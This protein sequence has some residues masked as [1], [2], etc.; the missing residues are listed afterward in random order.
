MGVLNLLN[1]KIIISRSVSP[2]LNLALEDFLFKNST[3][4]QCLLFYSNLPSVI[5]GRNQNPWTELNVR[6]CRKDW[7]NIVRRQSGGGTVFH[8]LGNVNY[9]VIMDRQNFSHTR[10]AQIMAKALQRS[11]IDASVNNRHDIVL[12]STGEKLSGSA[13]KIARSRCYHHG[14]MLLNT[15]LLNISKYLRSYTTGI[16]SSGVKSVRSPVV[17]V[18][19]PV[20]KFV[21]DAIH[22][23][24]ETYH[25]EKVPQITSITAEDIMGIEDIAKME[26]QLRSWNWTFGQTPKFQQTL[27]EEKLF[28][29]PL[30][31]NISVLHGRIDNAQ[32]VTEDKK[33]SDELST[34]DWN[35]LRYDSGSVNQILLQHTPSEDVRA[36]V[37]WLA[38]TI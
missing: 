26:E 22:T 4:K 25:L 6:Q 32:F 34:Y 10:N 2:Y 15:D 17:N 19:V 3:A 35:G 28:Q 1:A 13:Y 21:Y 33:L 8:D 14:T 16:R 27:K 5:I 18:N 12:S 24:L 31:V 7:V 37:S 9:S 29:H 23:Y 38:R 36:V 30:T 11:N 20:S